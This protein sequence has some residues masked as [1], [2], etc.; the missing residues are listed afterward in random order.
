MGDSDGSKPGF[1]A[2]AGPVT[3]PTTA[4][5]TPAERTSVPPAQSEGKAGRIIHDE[6]GNAVW[7]WLVETGRIFV[8]GTSRLLRR[9]ETPELK[10]E[11]DVNQELRIE[12]DGDEVGG[13]DPYG[14]SSSGKTGGAG[15]V[16]SAGRSGA[17]GCAGGGYDPYSKGE[18]R[19][20]GGKP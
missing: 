6:R 20:P 16:R 1:R 19:K 8:G 18:G 17:N 4:T 7:D 13:F 14:R 15:G 11:D 12:S 9:L 5:T 3:K 2:G 10:M